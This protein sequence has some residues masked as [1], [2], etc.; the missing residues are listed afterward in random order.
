MMSL[1]SA[2]HGISARKWVNNGDCA[3]NWPRVKRAVLA[4]VL[5]LVAIQFFQPQRTNPP[6]IPSRTLWAHEHVP[7]EVQGLLGRA[8][9]D[10]HSNRTVWPW[11]SRVAPISWVVADDVTQGRRHMN[12]EDWEGQQDAKQ[13][14]DHLIDVCKELMA[15]GMPPFSYRIAH[16]E[17]QLKTQEISVVCI[18]SRSF[19]ADS[20]IG[21]A[22]PP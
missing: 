16:R 19:E 14:N 7:Q 1:V 9:G 2:R 3:M 18:W 8:C 15:K 20:G 13:A 21:P 22:T 10:C 17:L 6:A 12:F 11:Y 5:F 4:L